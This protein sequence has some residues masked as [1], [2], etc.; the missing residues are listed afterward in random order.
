M[1]PSHSSRV[2]TFTADAGRPGWELPI[3]DAVDALYA[4]VREA[5]HR[6]GFTEANV[7][8]RF[9]LAS[10]VDFKSHREGRPE[11]RRVLDALEV[12]TD[13]FM[14]LAS[15][16]EQRA[17]A[18]LGDLAVDALLSLQLARAEQ[19]VEPALLATMLMYPTAGV[20]LVSDRTFGRPGEQRELPEDIVYPAITRNTNTFVR[21]VPSSRCH[22][23]L[24]MCA[25]NGVAAIANAAQS[26]HAWSLDLTARATSV[27]TFNARL[28][29]LTNVSVL[30]GDLYAP[31]E[32]LQFDRIVAHP[33][34]VPSA[35]Q[36]IIY[37]DGG[38]DGEMITRR[39]VADLPR[40]LRAGG[41]FF[42]TCIATDRT[43][44]PL[45]RRLHEW[46]GDARHEF[47]V[48]VAVTSAEHPSEYYFKSA[49]NGGTT[50]AKAEQQ[51]L[52]FKA[53]TVE[54]LVYSSFVIER[55]GTPRSSV[56][57]RVSRGLRTTG[58]ELEQ[59]CDWLAR[60]EASDLPQQILAAYPTIDR[61]ASLRQ[62]QRVIDHKWTV[63]DITFETSWPFV[64]AVQCPEDVARFLARCDGTRTVHQVITWL[65]QKGVLK[66]SVRDETVLQILMSCVAAGV[67]HLEDAALRTI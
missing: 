10:I 44:A 25:G 48:V 51:H 34:Y 28:N 43:E 66:S 17:R 38:P 54:R 16:P 58:R 12:V 3:T 64:G 30:Q 60:R 50:F 62:T 45:E 26:G 23:F 49:I 20:L 61:N 5:C 24:E 59:Y 19:G 32:G 36:A 13:L 15:V 35:E 42:C 27:A 52:T 2:Q 11:T 47:D 39:I 21:M 65:R 40:F 63:G 1:T 14:D 6:A 53:M 29:G 22:T 67:V 46:L 4:A 37:R 33:P 9:A 57:V 18:L 7:C 31:V 56:C 41:R 55:H 8:A